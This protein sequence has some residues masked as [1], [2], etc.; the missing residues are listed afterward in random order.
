ML[1]LALAG[2]SSGGS[3]P[4]G[5]GESRT[6]APSASASASASASPDTSEPADVSTSLNAPDAL[7]QPVCR[8]TADGSWSFTGTLVNSGDKDRTFTVAIAVTAGPAV[9][10]HTI[11]TK[12]V[13][14]GQSAEIA[15][16][17]FAQ[18]KDSAGICTPVVSVEDAP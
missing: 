8:A 16:P 9:A 3:A 1:L 18:T 6:A 17:N 2:C 4:A 11:I 15:A 7:R 12:T 10:G 13:A 14:A 5:P